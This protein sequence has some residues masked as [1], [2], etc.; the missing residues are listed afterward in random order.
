MEQKR[1]IVVPLS[2]EPE[3]PHF[4]AEE[5]LLSARPV[6]PLAGGETRRAAHRNG[7]AARGPFYRSLPFLALIV[8]A[9]IGI[10]TL[11][12][13]GI[14][15][16]Q[17][18]QRG[19]SSVATQPVPAPAADTRTTATVRTPDVTAQPQA[20]SVPEV[21]IE[22]K[23][24]ET[25][26]AAEDS[27][28]KAPASRTKVSDEVEDKRAEGKKEDKKENKREDKRREDDVQTL[29]PPSRDRGR[30][31]ENNDDDIPPRAQRRERRQRDR[32]SD[33]ITDVPRQIERVD[34]QINRIREIFEGRQQRP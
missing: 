23:S 22:D 19:A 25:E 12:G 4:D 14:A 10:G 17:Y 11:G 1:K 8:V 13:L 3:T 26:T 28:E 16:Y 5:T 32:N 24:A 30:T 29:P 7:P 33:G 34:E 21:R 6:V 18:E 27:A 9:A 31:Y 20:P 2:S 15:R